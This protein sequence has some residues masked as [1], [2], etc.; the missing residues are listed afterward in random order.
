VTLG[1]QATCV[2]WGHAGPADAPAAAHVAGGACHLARAAESD[3]DD[4]LRHPIDPEEEDG[5]GSS[6]RREWD[7]RRYHSREH[8]TA[9]HRPPDPGVYSWAVEHDGHCIGGAGLRVDAD[10]HCA[11]YTVGLFVAG[12]RGRG[13]GREVTR[14]VL[15]WSFDVLGV[16]RV[17]LEVLS[18]NTRAINC[19]LACGFRQEGVRRKAEL[20]PDGWKDFIMM[21]QLRSEHASQAKIARRPD[22]SQGGLTPTVYREP[23]T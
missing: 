12:L 13:L 16:H 10:Q 21:G 4:R 17:Q 11:T 23:D 20:Y 18:S 9:D 22:P 7:G 8:L 14:L 2:A 5:Y 1:W 19:Y 15:S 3:V 6:W